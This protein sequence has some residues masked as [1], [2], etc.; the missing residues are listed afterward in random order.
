MTKKGVKKM[1][2]TFQKDELLNALQA[3]QKGLSTKNT[4]PHLNGFLIQAENDSELSIITYD[5][6]MGIKY[7]LSPKIIETGSIVVP[8]KFFDIIRK[9]PEDIINFS[10]DLENL[11]ISIDSGQVYYEIKGLDP[12]EYPQLPDILDQRS[13]SIPE[14][15]LKKMIHQTSFAVSK[16]ETKPAFTGVLCKFDSDNKVDMVATDSFRLAWRKG[17]IVN[18]NQIEGEYIIPQKAI[19]QVQKLVGE[20]DTLIKL[21]LSKDYFLCKTDNVKL[22]SKLIDEQFPNL[23][24]VI[25]KN[26]QTKVLLDRKILQ[27]SMERASLLASEGAN[28]IVKLNITEEN[29][30]ITSNSPHTGKLKEDMQIY[31]EGDNLSIAIN[32]RFVIEVLKVIDEDQV[33]LEFT[34]SYSPMIVR[35]KDNDQYFHLILPVRAF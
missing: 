22:F 13:L 21:N 34:G 19:S 11:L 14:I 35:P 3:T 2:I 9:L 32:A 18:D 15:L 25:P 5:L 16:E 29:L 17:K 26:Y 20:E 31:K 27:D 10:V 8:G 30:E 1:K 4:I 23:E 28:N 7:Y 33:E 12:T 6:E 24:Q